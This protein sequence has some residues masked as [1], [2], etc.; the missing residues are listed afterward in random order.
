MTKRET[1][2]KK[3]STYQFAALD[4][5]I[6]L[7]THP[8]DRAALEKAEKYKAMARPLIEQYEEQ[9]GPLTKRASDVNSW[10]WIKGP[11]PWESED[12]C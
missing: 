10:T 4:M 9:Y 1:L 2:L 3:I 6:Y 7:D 12:D 11:W 8:N 5:Q